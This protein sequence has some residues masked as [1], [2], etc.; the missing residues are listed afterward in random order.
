MLEFLF[1]KQK[2]KKKI[3]RNKEFYILFI[4]LNLFSLSIKA[5]C[6][7]CKAAVE[8]NLEGGGTKGSGLNDGILY[9]MAMPYLAVLFFYL[10][11]N[12]FI[13]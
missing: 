6:A 8:A 5:Q 4:S 7:M 11:Q 2:E 1:L 12:N 3:M 9:L 13:S 10:I